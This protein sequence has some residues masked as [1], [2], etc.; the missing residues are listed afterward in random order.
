MTESQALL[1]LQEIDLE[2]MRLNAQLKA[3]PQ[4]KKLAAIQAAEKNLAGKLKT[5]V[6]QRKDAEIDLDDNEAAQLKTKDRV[7]E[8][9]AEAQQRAQDF[10]GVRDLEAHLTALAKQLEKLEYKHR[11]LEGN[12]EKLMK[13]EQNANDLAAKLNDERAVQQESYER[14]SADIM[15][16]VRVLAAERK[17][18]LADI[19]QDVADKYAKAAKRFGGLAVE[20]LRG[21]M[22]TTCRVK[23]QQGIFGEL[24]RGPIITE[25]PYCHRMLVTEGALVDE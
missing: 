24:M 7:S 21:N 8:I 4:Q 6:G 13:A 10:R 3:M 17:A 16:R 23:L 2:L 9:Q 22:P 14:Q 18:V 11:E 1:R 20:R 12:L 5:I 25:C 15:A 19:S